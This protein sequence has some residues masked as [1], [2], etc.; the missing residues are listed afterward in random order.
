MNHV[1]VVA[2]KCFWA[3][4]ITASDRRLSGLNQ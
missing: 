1:K 3:P 2:L 4:K